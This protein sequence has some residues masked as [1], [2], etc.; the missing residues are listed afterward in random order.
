[1]IGVHLRLNLIPDHA[2]RRNPYFF[3]AR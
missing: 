2:D 1:V 3:G